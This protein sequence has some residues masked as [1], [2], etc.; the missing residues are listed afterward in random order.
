MS[1]RSWT[2]A[3][4]AVGVVFALAALAFS[5]QELALM[6]N[7]AHPNALAQFAPP[8]VR[9]I[10]N[11]GLQAARDAWDRLPWVVLLWLVSASCGVGVLVLRGHASE[12]GSDA[13]VAS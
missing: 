4:A 2:L 5:S 11:P 9:M 13:S 12:A 1:G 6:Y 10:P 3:L 7:A 8:G